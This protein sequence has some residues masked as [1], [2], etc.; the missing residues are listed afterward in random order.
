[1]FSI[2]VDRACIRR[3]RGEVDVVQSAER[4]SSRRGGGGG[5]LMCV[6]NADLTDCVRG[7]GG[8]GGK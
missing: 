3:E 7:G 6:A 1:M 4:L 5:E 8:W 2:N